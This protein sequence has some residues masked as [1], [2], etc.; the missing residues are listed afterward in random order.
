MATHDEGTA[1]G[2]AKPKGTKQ[3]SPA[4]NAVAVVLLV[5]FSAV[6]YLEW[7]A[8]RQ[9]GAAIARLNQAMARDEDGGDL[10][11]K[12]QVEGMIGRGPDGPG[13]DEDGETKVTYTVE[14]GH[15]QVPPHH[16]LHEASPRRSSSASNERVPRRA[17]SDRRAGWLRSSTLAQAHRD[18]LRLQVRLQPLVAQLAAQARSPS[19]R[20]TGTAASPAP[21]R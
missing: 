9:S 13:V 14:G 18:V 3:V 7:N 19:C 16:L 17:G 2:R 11:S 6:A 20:R 15:P 21:G 8:N 1:R 5:A 4:R 10:L 12:E